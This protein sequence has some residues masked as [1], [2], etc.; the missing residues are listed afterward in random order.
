MPMSSNT[1]SESKMKGNNLRL[2]YM[3]TADFALPSLERLVDEGYHVCAVV[4][5]Q[6]VA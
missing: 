2:I 5:M 1:Y 3:A 4:T 6:D